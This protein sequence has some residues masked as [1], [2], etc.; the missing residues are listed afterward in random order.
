[1][2][3]EQHADDTGDDRSD[4]QVMRDYLHAY[5]LTPPPALAEIFARVP[6]RLLWTSREAGRLDLDAT[7]ALSHLCSW[8]LLERAPNTEEKA[9]LI[10]MCVWMYEASPRPASESIAFWCYLARVHGGMSWEE[11]AGYATKMGEPPLG[12]DATRKRIERWAEANHLE[13]PGR[14][15]RPPVLTPK[16]GTTGTKKRDKRDKDLAD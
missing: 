1:M 5:E 13:P 9:R 3:D 14:Y 2:S 10:S 6:P 8:V 12:R 7:L 16:R 15:R 4:E 11:V